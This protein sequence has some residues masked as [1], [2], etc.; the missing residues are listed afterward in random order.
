MSEAPASLQLLTEASR[1]LADIQNPP[2]HCSD[3]FDDEVTT[4]CGTPVHPAEAPASVEDKEA[5]A[6]Q[7]TNNRRKIRDRKAGKNSKAGAL[8]TGLR[9]VGDSVLADMKGSGPQRTRTTETRPVARKPGEVLLPWETAAPLLVAEKPSSSSSSSSRPHCSHNTAE[10]ALV[11]PAK[12]FRGY[13]AAQDM[14]VPT[15]QLACFGQRE[16]AY[17]ALDTTCCAQWTDGV[18]QALCHAGVPMKLPAESWV[19]EAPGFD[20]SLPLKKAVTDFLFTESLIV[21]YL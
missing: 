17:N 3:N 8:R 20:S 13:S 16:Q 21:Y 11:V 18:R 6:R 5:A 9:S 14:P 19:M 7:K 2:K 10:P 4:C 1:K 12:A 15:P